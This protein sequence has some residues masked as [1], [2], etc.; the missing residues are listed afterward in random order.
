MTTRYT[1]VH[2][3]TTGGGLT[4]REDVRYLEEGIM[5]TKGMKKRVWTPREMRILTKL[6][7]NGENSTEIQDCSSH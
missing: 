6:A 3:L 2:V 5:I 1:A 4:T 7:H